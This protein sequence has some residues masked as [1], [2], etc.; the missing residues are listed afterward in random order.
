[1]SAPAE[2]GGTVNM[3]GGPTVDMSGKQPDLEA[4]RGSSGAAGAGTGIAGADP[5]TG[6]NRISGGGSGGA[7]TP[8]D[9]PAAA[10]VEYVKKARHPGVCL[11]HMSFKLICIGG[12]FLG[13]YG[14]ENYVHTFLLCVIV[15]ALDFWTVKNVTGRL[16]VGLRWWNDIQDDGSSKWVFESNI[17]EAKMD[18]VDTAIFWNF[19]YIWVIFWVFLFV[20]N[21]LS[22]SL[23]WLLLVSVGLGFSMANLI[24]FWKCS[25]HKQKKMTQA[26]AGYLASRV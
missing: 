26:M 5:T 20:V 25:K 18:P 7:R 4:G 13:R 2:G 1:M 19:T 23:N 16:L 3:S 10:A 8:Q 14:W 22:L 15:S 21:L 6:E 24:G 17:S 12:Y 9:G 11:T